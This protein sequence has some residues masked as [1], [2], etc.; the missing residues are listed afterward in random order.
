VL[1]SRH[2][3]HEPNWAGGSLVVRDRLTRLVVS[4]LFPHKLTVAYHVVP[5]RWYYVVSPVR[6][7]TCNLRLR[8]VLNMWL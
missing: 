7:L 1:V 3:V 4:V 2:R 8:L 5:S 6:N